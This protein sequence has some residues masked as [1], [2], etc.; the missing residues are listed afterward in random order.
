MKK[1]IHNRSGATPVDLEKQRKRVEENYEKEKH[2]FRI[3]AGGRAVFVYPKELNKAGYFEL[4][5]LEELSV[6][7]AFMFCYD[8]VPSTYTEGCSSW[9]EEDQMCDMCTYVC[10]YIIH[11]RELLDWMKKETE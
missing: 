3:N 10:D 6:K 2:A 9:D 8:Y 7:L 11:A 4:P 1:N 5:T